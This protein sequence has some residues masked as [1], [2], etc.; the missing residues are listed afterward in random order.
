MNDMFS[1]DSIVAMRR[2]AIIMAFRGLKPTA[3]VIGPLRGLRYVFATAETS[4]KLREINV[5]IRT[6]LRVV[7]NRYSG[8][9]GKL[10]AWLS[11]S[12]AEKAPKKK[13]APTP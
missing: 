2:D 4:S 1:I 13:D 9:P 10:A 7:R 5:A 3:K 11:A 12:H 8:A 6:G